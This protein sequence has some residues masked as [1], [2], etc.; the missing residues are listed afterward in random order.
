[1]PAMGYIASDAPIEH[2]FRVEEGVRPRGRSK[3]DLPAAR[4]IRVAAPRRTTDRERLRGQGAVSSEHVHRAVR[5]GDECPR[6]VDVATTI[7]ERLSY[8]R[9]APVPSIQA[10]HLPTRARRLPREGCAS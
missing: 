5:P 1:M 3:S 9:N 10:G 6:A 4:C 8:D 7:Q 2:V